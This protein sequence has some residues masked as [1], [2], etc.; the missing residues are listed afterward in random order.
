MRFQKR[1][2]A[3][4]SRVKKI[5]DATFTMLL[6]EKKITRETISSAVHGADAS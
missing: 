5:V 6:E 1:Y 3:F 2:G 4:N